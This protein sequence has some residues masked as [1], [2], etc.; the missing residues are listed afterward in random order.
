MWY[1]YNVDCVKYMCVR[2][3]LKKKT[4]G[5][6]LS[7]VIATIDIHWKCHSMRKVTKCL[8]CAENRDI[9]Y[10]IINN[11]ILTGMTWYVVTPRKTPSTAA[12]PRSTMFPRGD[13]LQCHPVKKCN[14]YIKHQDGHSWTTGGQ[15]R[16]Q[17]PG[18]RHY[19]L[20]GKIYQTSTS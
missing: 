9:W 5:G 15:R 11:T 16:D 19:I 20:H 4:N 8:S 3:E 12:R 13:N 18:R 17:V 6:I 1:L 14:I 10:N 2:Y 7:N